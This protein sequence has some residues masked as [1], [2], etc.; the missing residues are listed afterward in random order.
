[1]VAWGK[2]GGRIV[3]EVGNEEVHT[4]IFKWMTN[5]DLL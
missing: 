1:M 5:Q 3:K 4:A 2:N